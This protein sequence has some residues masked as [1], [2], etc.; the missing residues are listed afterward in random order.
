VISGSEL[1][2]ASERAAA[3]LHEFDDVNDRLRIYGL[4]AQEVIELVLERWDA[5]EDTDPDGEARERFVQAY[6]E[7]LL[8]GLQAA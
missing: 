7:G 2:T 1:R 3:R 4:E 8:T 6:V 5:Y